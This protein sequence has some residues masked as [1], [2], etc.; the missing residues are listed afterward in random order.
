MKTFP[1]GYSLIEAVI[2]L[3]FVAAA[4]CAASA[5]LKK[6]IDQHKLKTETKNIVVAMDDL[7]LRAMQRGR[8]VRVEI[9][10]TGYAAWEDGICFLQKTLPRPLHFLEESTKA[11]MFYPKGVT[12]P[13]TLRL[14]DRKSECRIITSLRGRV[15]SQCI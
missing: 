6:G 1:G 10:S 13:A 12:S 4:L 11:I 3:V 9:Q 14:S 8:A 2:V 7:H 5:S 15:R